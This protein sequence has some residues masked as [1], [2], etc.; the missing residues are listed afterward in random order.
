M[1]AITSFTSE[2]LNSLREKRTLPRLLSIP[3]A[4]L[5]MGLVDMGFATGNV[6]LLTL[7]TVFTAS[8]M[9][10][11]TSA[12]HEA[13]HQT[14]WQSRNLSVWSGRLLGTFMFTPYSMYREVHIRHHAYLN[15]PRDWELWPYCDPQTS[16]GFR[17][18]FVWFDL[19]LGVIA[20]PVIYGRMFFKKDSPID[21]P[22]LRRT[23]RNEYLAI[24]A[25]WGGIWLFV[26]IA[27]LWP[28]HALAVLLPMYLAALM[29]TIRKFTEHLGMASFDPLR[30]T[31]TVLPRQ[32]LL[33]LSSFL[34]FD[35][36][37]HGPHHRHPRI[38]HTTLEDKLEEH[39]EKNPEADY[40]TYERYWQATWAM[41]PALWNPGCGVN[42][43]A[44]EPTP[45]VAVNDFVPDVVAERGKPSNRQ[46]A[47]V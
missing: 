22:E 39:Q 25:V 21:S 7:L 29:Q 5:S 16:L 36:F 35:I 42:A 37:V 34:N 41:L 13:A 15:T 40:P 32:W 43:G 30:G 44:A 8:M 11:W 9:F 4:G 31:R 18:V 27:G 47:R 14:L 6:W 26:T 20:G 46:T 3:L 23:I 28:R 19:L 17:R 2:E 45:A 24:A 12:L 10:C 33:R 1:G 38:A